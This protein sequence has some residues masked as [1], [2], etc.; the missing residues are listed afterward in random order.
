MAPKFT[1][2]RLRKS[3]KLFGLSQREAALLLGVTPTQLMEW[4]CGKRMPMG[5]N[6]FKLGVLYKRLIEDIYYEE[7]LEAIREVEA[8]RRKYGILGTDRPP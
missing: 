3:R 2:Y 4:E 5:R 8:N 7:R 6:L 1:G